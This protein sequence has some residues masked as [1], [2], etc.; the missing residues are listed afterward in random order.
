MVPINEPGH[1]QTE[2][3]FPPYLT[4]EEEAI[5]PSEQAF[6]NYYLSVIDGL[7]DRPNV[8]FELWNEPVGND[9]SR[10][11]WFRITQQVITSAR[12]ITDHPILIH[13]NYGI[14][15]NLDYG[16][17]SKLDWIE[18]YP[19]NDPMNNL[20]YSTHIYRWGG[21]CHRSDS[22]PAEDRNRWEYNEIELCLNTTLVNY[23][24][25]DLE[26]PLVIGEIGAVLNDDRGHEYFENVLDIFNRW[27]ISYLAWWWRPDGIFG[28]IDGRSTRNPNSVGHL[29]IKAVA[30]GGIYAINFTK[31]VRDENNN[32]IGTNVTIERKDK[33]YDL[34]QNRHSLITPSIYNVSYILPNTL[35]K[36]VSVNLTKTNHNKLF[37]VNLKENRKSF[38]FDSYETQLVKINSNEKPTRLLKNNTVLQEYENSN[39]LRLNLG[40][41][42]DSVNK[43]I[44][45]RI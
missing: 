11:D 22:V 20:I 24:I 6:V 38:F 9:Q 4:P 7:K 35:V 1:K 28:L 44:F 23:V 2:I 42:Y 43:I 8:I 36:I 21:F 13:W 41:Y 18:N 17:G 19:L 3:P 39:D 12:Q 10:D 29:L 45:M 30:N 15:A 33:T 5:L 31:D 34:F 26:K 40:W 27:G 25:N 16:G 37:M 14:Y 32:I